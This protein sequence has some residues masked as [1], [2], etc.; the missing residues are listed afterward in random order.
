MDMIAELRLRLL[1]NH[2]TTNLYIYGP[3]P[4]GECPACDRTRRAIEEA[5]ERYRQ[6]P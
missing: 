6:T 2:S 1:H 5:T 4:S 3:R